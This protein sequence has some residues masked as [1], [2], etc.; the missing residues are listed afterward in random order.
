M[1]ANFYTISFVTRFPLIFVKIVTSD[2]VRYDNNCSL[3]MP[4]P[5][6]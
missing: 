5:D 6:S 1:K 3:K 2:S 4:F